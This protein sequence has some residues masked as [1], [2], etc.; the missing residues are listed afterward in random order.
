M[1]LKYE[2]KSLP[3]E[4]KQRRKVSQKDRWLLQKWKGIVLKIN[5]LAQ[6]FLK[7]R[8]YKI[9]ERLLKLPRFHQ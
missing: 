2:K 9:E 5:L 3:V 4:K 7:C 1:I 8:T 6:V